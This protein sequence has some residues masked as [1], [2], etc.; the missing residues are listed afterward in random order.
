V[1]AL[2]FNLAVAH[3]DGETP[4]E[5]VYFLYTPRIDANRDKDLLQILPDYLVEEI[6]FDRVNAAKFYSRICDTLT[7]KLD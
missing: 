5:E 6:Q 7:R 2:H 3:D 1:L 4:Y